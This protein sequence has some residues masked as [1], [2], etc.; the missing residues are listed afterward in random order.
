DTPMTTC[1]RLIL[2]FFSL[3][4]V[5]DAGCGKTPESPTTAQT[6]PTLAKTLADAA[7]NA[8]PGDTIVLPAGLYDAGIT[9]PSGVRLRGAG[10][11]KTIL[12]ARKAEVGLAIQG[13]E[14]AEIA[15]LTVWGASKTDVLVVDAAKVAVR[16]VRT[17]GGL[18]GV[19]FSG[20]TEGR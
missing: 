5:L 13:G 18:N 15:D 19:N 11:R 9:L 4:L 8:R 10:F 6:A 2:A 20:V 7:A 1:S 3:P 14:G 12:D 16:R 17:T